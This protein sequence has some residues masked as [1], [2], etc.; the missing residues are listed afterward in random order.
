MAA[1]TSGRMMPPES[2][3]AGPLALISVRTPNPA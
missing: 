1:A 2:L 3:V